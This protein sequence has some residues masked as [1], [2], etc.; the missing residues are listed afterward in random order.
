MSLNF[1]DNVFETLAVSMDEV[2]PEIIEVFLQ[3]T[4]SSIDSMKIEIAANNIDKVRGIAHKIKSSAKTFGAL[5]LVEI[6]ENIENFETS[7][8]AELTT[9]QQ[10][11]A[12]EYA[13]VKKHILAK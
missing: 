5:S 1:D 8:G 12:E 10:N 2:F 7:I 11:L 6:L 3:E 4:E 9:A 13:A